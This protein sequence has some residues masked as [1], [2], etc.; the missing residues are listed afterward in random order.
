MR[1]V[2]RAERHRLQEIPEEEAYLDW[3]LRLAGERMELAEA[4]FIKAVE[5]SQSIRELWLAGEVQQEIRD[6]A[7]QAQQA[8]WEAWHEAV[9]EWWQLL[10]RKKG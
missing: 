4:A 7:D 10:L 6:E 1:A 2:P 3:K 5:S 8:A 9:L